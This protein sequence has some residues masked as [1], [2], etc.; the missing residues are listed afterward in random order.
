MFKAAILTAFLAV[1]VNADL[2][3][4]QF[5][6]QYAR[7]RVMLEDYKAQNPDLFPFFDPGSLK[8]VDWRDGH[9]DDVVR[10]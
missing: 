9:H 8:D 3:S 4:P 6:E 7:L 10:I 2:H 5:D 1:A